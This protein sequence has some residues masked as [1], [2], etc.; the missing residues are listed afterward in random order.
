MTG[1]ML[2]AYILS[3]V[4]SHIEAIIDI[5]KEYDSTAKSFDEVSAVIW[6]EGDTADI[7]H[8]ANL[9]GHINQLFALARNF[10][11]DLPE[12]FKAL[13]VWADVINPSS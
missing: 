2:T 6:E 1:D 13:S 9:G 5:A 8:A 3:E 4:P 11:L 12:E 7:C 10:N